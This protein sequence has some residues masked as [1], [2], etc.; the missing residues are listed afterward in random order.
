MREGYG[1]ETGS[2]QGFAAKNAEEVRKVPY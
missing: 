2:K 1:A